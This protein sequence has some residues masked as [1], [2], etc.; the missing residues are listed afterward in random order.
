M[1]SF[2]AHL[3][4]FLGMLA[5][6]AAIPFGLPGAGIILLSI[7]IYAL[8]T[9]FSAAVGIPLFVVLC[10]FTLVAET[11]DNWLTAVGARSY[12]ASTASMWLSFLG[13]LV[14]A[15][16]IG[17]PLAVA[18][19]PFGPVAAGF[20]GA[21]AVVVGYE[22]YLGRNMREALQA[23]WGT[24]LGR[25]AGMVLKLVISIAMITAVALAIA[26]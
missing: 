16:M 14:G 19:G 4:L 8:L 25:M 15:L 7:F 26:F 1:E 12:G 3:L 11:A 23:G 18:F 21:F 20:I 24:F 17:G 5:G 10:I 22:L 6:L 13:G 9:H 2:L